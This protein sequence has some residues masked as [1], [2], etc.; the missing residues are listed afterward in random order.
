[1]EEFSPDIFK[2]GPK[3]EFR[4]AE[5]AVI[6]MVDLMNQEKINLQ[7]VFKKFEEQNVQSY[8]YIMEFLKL[9]CDQLESTYGL[10]IDFKAL[11][12][13]A[14]VNVDQDWPDRKEKIAEL[15]EL[16]KQVD[17]ISKKDST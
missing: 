2:K 14:R 13:T 5:E 8:V 6:F 16:F 11:I 12:E 3:M 7:A 4:N 9:L 17:D 10:K 15:L 1:M